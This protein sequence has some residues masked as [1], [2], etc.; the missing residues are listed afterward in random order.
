M[1][2]HIIDWTIVIV[3]MGFIT[4]MA[5]YTQRYTRSVA[6]F[7]AANRCAGRYLLTIAQGAAAMGAITVLQKFETYYEAGFPLFF[8]GMAAVPLSTFVIMSGFVIYRYRRTRAMTIAQFF[9]M[10]YSRRF[11]IFAGFITWLS[12]MVNFG[13]FPA[14]GARF[15]IN[16]CGI[17]TYMTSLGP[18][19][20][21]VTMAAVMFVLVG[22]A[23]YFTLCGGQI[24]VIV[25]DFW[26]GV[27]ATLTFAAVVVLLLYLFPWE[28][29]TVGMQLASAPGK[30]LFNPFDIGRQDNFNVYF[31][32]IA[33]FF[34]L[35]Q[36]MA[37]QGMSGY[38]CSAI[39]PHEQ[40]MAR[41]LSHL[42]AAMVLVGTVLMPLAVITYL[43]HPDYAQKAVEVTQALSS[44]FPGDEVLQTQMRVPVVLSRILPRGLIGAFVVSMLGF[45]ISTNN[46]YLHSWGSIF[47]QDILCPLRKKPLTNKQHMFALRASIVGVA[48]FIYLFSTFFEI[49]EYIVMFFDITGAIYLGG[50][51]CVIIGGLYWK[52][53]TTKAA[54]AAFISGSTL[55]LTTIILRT[56]WDK[57][58]FL[59]SISPE[60]PFNSRVMSFFCA[61]IA[62]VL[63]VIIS[64]FDK[65]PNINMDKILH[66]GEYAIKEEEEELAKKT[67]QKEISTLWRFIGVNNHEFSRVD[68]GLFIYVFLWAVFKMGAF[69]LLCFLK[70]IG[71][72]GTAG[73]FL[74][75]QIW[76]IAELITAFI[77]VFWITI[78]GFFDLGKMYKRLAAVVRDEKDDGSVLH[79]QD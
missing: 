46:T 59:V 65:D 36:M 8:W 30:S 1:N 77:G 29:I 73:W 76:I 75:F 51:G 37:W 72:I 4:A 7:L 17:P 25:T 50:A 21:N 54:F 11:R 74:S 58:P 24:A 32:L 61:V 15:F 66:R 55:A 64:L 42:R 31:Y 44:T 43:H 69:L 57:V 26:Q 47:V 10:R 28:K 9:E 62:I 60:F 22:L 13:V 45:F 78:G 52:R 20:I 63:Y 49:K 71:K 53:G 67:E 16:F 38:N 34:V 79:E 33:G 19:E 70:S 5:V 56:I 2:M 40:K 14:I 39:T 3:V 41:V 18:F 68:R 12:G 23:L 27:F 48:I 6:D 35:Y